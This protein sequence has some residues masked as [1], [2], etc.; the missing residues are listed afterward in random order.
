MWTLEKR[1]R[2]ESGTTHPQK[3]KIITGFLA[4]DKLYLLSLQGLG[5]PFLG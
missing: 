2:R 5:N 3:Y 4:E 1:D